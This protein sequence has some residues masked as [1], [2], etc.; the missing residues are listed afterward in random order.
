MAKTVRDPT[1]AA[2]RQFSLVLA[3]VGAEFGLSRTDILSTV[4]G[5]RR[6]FEAEGATT[7]L[8][9]KFERDKE[10]LRDLGVDVETLDDPSAAGDNQHTRYRIRE[11]RVRMPAAIQLDADEAA[12]LA[13]AAAVWREGSLSGESRRGLM[14][15]RARGIDVRRDV[16]NIAPRFRG[17]EPE[18]DDFASAIED[19]VVAEFDYRKQRAIEDERRRVEPLALIH[20][21]GKWLLVAF[22]L[23]RGEERR[24]LLQRVQ[25][26]VT[27]QGP[28][29]EDRAAARKGRNVA[30]ESLVELRRLAASQ[31]VIIDVARGS[32]AELR[33]GRRAASIEHRSDVSRLTVET[34]DFELLAD[35]LAEFGPELVVREPPLLR[36]AVE[37]RLRR[38]LDEHASEHEH[39]P[40]ASGEGEANAD[41]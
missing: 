16:P 2:E 6:T 8:T 33:L 24:F 9:R 39:G 20:F 5:Y 15:L 27:T 21:G 18:F 32:D 13:F 40:E 7:A 22:D 4:H 14:K 3:L 19:G 1:S 23:D 10:D 34:A 25:S 35:E 30:E 38:V 12:L 28:I 37:H 31:P 17:R 26:D 29:D 41:R 11:D 36:D